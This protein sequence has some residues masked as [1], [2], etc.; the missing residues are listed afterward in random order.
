M[1]TKIKRIIAVTL[2]TTS[3]CLIGLNS[4]S[5]VHK[6]TITDDSIRTLQDSNGQQI[7]TIYADAVEV[8]NTNGYNCTNDKDLHVTLTKDNKYIQVEY[9][10]KTIEIISNENIKL[11]KVN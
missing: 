5:K 7:M 3:I 6:T 11:S 2:L 8:E 4:H 9:T 10:E 1:N